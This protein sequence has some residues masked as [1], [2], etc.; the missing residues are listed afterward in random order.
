MKITRAFLIILFAGLISCHSEIEE[1][2]KFTKSSEIFDLQALPSINI[3][4]SI[5]E[6]NKLLTNFDINPFNEVYVNCDFS[7][8]KDGKS[9]VLKNCG[10]RIKGNTSRRRPEGKTGEVHNSTAPDW[11]HAHFSLDFNHLI[12]E[13]RFAGLKKLNFKWF[14]DDS[15]YARE[16][17]CYDLF[18]R[19]G[20][21]TAPRASYCLFELQ[22]EDEETAFFGVY[23]LLE[24]VDDVFIKERIQIFGDNKGYLWKANWGADLVNKDPNRMGIEIA[25][26]YNTQKP[27]YDF[28]GDSSQLETAKLE[29]IQF[30]DSLNLKKGGEFPEWFER[31]CNPDL[32]LK[33]YNVSTLCGMWDDYWINKNNYYFYINSMGEFFFIPYD[34]DNTLGTSQIIPDAGT[35]DLLKWGNELHPLIKRIISFTS[36]KSAY[37]NNF[38]E[39][40][41]PTNDLFDASSSISRIQNWHN[42]IQNHIQND[43][44]E[45][46]EIIDQPAWW[47]NQPHYRLLNSENNYF[48][49]RA[50]HLPAIN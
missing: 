9:E 13:Q 3:K 12:P 50:S 20:V 8:T 42:L 22:I 32:L 36:Y 34:Y 28:K 30:I 26:L 21:S 38:H 14:K 37:I 31:K 39:L 27:V 16:I 11:H 43:T 48:I 17:Y 10:I 35:Q 47:G 15:M 33:T 41:D 2:P 29:L 44:G 46:M 19:Y 45:D 24:A 5:D 4:I 6:W 40:C 18:K 23:E 7:F 49:I 1:T 25:E